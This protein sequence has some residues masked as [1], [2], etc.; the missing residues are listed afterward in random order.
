MNAFVST[1]YLLLLLC[2]AVPTAIDG[3]FGGLDELRLVVRHDD[4][5][6]DW[7]PQQRKENYEAGVQSWEVRECRTSESK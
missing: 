6:C 7:E 3:L 1:P 2:L 5:R 4:V